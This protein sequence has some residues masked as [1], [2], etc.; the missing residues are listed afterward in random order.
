MTTDCRTTKWIRVR[1]GNPCPVCESDSWC[2]VSEDGSVALCMRAK[3][4]HPHEMQNGETAYIHRLTDAPACPTPRQPKPKGPTDI[5]RHMMLGPLA[6]QWCRGCDEQV[7]TLAKELGVA[8]WALDELLV[9]WNENERCWTFPERNQSKQIVGITRRFVGGKKLAVIGGGRGMSF[10][11]DWLDYDGPLFIVEGGSDTAAG[12]TLGLPVIGRQSNL[13]GVK[14]L[15]RML[16]GV[17]RKMI[18][19]AERDEKDRATLPEAH[20]A[21]CLCCNMCYPG[22][23][24]AVQTSIRLSRE[25]QTLVA[26]SFMPDGAKDMRSWLNQQNADPENEQAMNRLGASLI[27]RMQRGFKK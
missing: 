10:S 21:G 12:L 13:G 23:H 5:E 22:K 6:R 11:D 9:G 27:R 25:L 26:W 1:R 15:C 3:S 4:D 24:G 14:Y 7:A 20:K 17:R 8:R 19:V 18:V 16:R 2:L